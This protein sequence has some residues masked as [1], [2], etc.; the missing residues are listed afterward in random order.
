MI[1]TFKNT[2]NSQYFD[3][4]DKRLE[5]ILQG[6][7]Q[8]N[9]T[10]K[11]NNQLDDNITLNLQRTAT[12]LNVIKSRLLNLDKTIHDS[13]VCSFEK[14]FHVWDVNHTELTP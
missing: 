4:I 9:Q 5:N 10:L 12:N 13:N 2:S 11:C 1:S 7:K 3:S 6:N 14:L 8:N